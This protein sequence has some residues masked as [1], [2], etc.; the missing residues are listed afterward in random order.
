MLEIIERA[1]TI[2]TRASRAYKELGKELSA[3]ELLQAANKADRV[4]GAD[5]AAR[6]LRIM[7]GENDGHDY[8]VRQS[9][10][11]KCQEDKQRIEEVLRG[12]NH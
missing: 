8:L 3:H 11:L 4:L 5:D 9:E 10:C 6:W 12:H 2:R 1:A 7:A